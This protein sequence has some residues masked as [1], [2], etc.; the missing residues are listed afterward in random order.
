MIENI[1]LPDT[2][3]KDSHTHITNIFN[4]MRRIKQIGSLMITPSEDFRDWFTS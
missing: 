3:K 4:M 1:K 2:N